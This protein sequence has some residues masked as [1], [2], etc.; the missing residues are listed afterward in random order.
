M[1]GGLIQLNAYGAQN[2]YLNGNPQMSYFKTVYRRYTN[3]SMEN[4]RINLDGPNELSVE[5]ASK[6]SCRIDRNGDLISQIY[7]VFNLPD[8]YS[9]YD[10]LNENR[11]LS[12]YRFQWIESIGTNIINSVT[13][14]IG[15]QAVSTLYGDWIRIWHELFSPGNKATFDEMT[16]NLPELFSPQFATGNN[17]TYP[18]S[19]LSKNL[20]ID[21]DIFSSSQYLSNPYLKPP[22]IKGRTVYVPIPFWFCT[23][24]GLALPLIALQYH[25][26]KLYIEL[27]KLSEIYTIMETRPSDI[28]YGKRVAPNQIKDYHSIQNFISN[29]PSYNFREGDDFS[30]SKDGYRGWGLDPHL[31]VNYIFLD[32]DER[33]RFADLSHEYLIEQVNRYEFIGVV[34]QKTLDLKLSNP[35]KYL[36]WYAL[37][38]DF[39]KK[40]IFD[41]FTNWPIKNIDVGSLSYI[42]NITGEVTNKYNEFNQLQGI[43]DTAYIAYQQN[44]IPSKFNFRYFPRDIITSH[45]LLFNGVQRFN[46]RDQYYFNYTQPHQH[47]LYS[48]YPGLYFYSFSLEPTK[49]QPSGACNMSKLKTIQLQIKTI[50]VMSKMTDE[51]TIDFQHKFNIYVYSV[52]YNIFRVLAGMGGLSFNS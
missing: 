40:N 16:G 30:S 25:E 10:I 36:V 20:N 2:Q 11:E 41:N 12:V 17:S 48:T 34:G 43:E 26:V 6:L 44:N 15:G 38:D 37:R 8:I 24:S 7:F 49:I 19:T 45:T 18:T 3:F 13:I 4:L 47:S 51:N 52:N 9:G 50:D 5:S 29:I 46:T 27:K 21:P 33:K 42:R 1:P 35:V 23:N 39:Y 32:E 31:D 22:S 14:T 28:D